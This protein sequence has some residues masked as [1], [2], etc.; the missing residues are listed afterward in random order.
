LTE[1]V[2]VTGSAY[3][4][5]RFRVEV[6][7]GPDVGLEFTSNSDE[8]TIGTEH[9]NDVALTDPTVSRHHCSLRVEP[10]GVMLRD[11]GSTNGTFVGGHRIES[12][13]LRSG[14]IIKVGESV[15]RFD[16]LAE[17]VREELSESESL[18]KLLGK[19]AAMR[20]VMAK[21]A[22]FA[23]STSTVLIEGETGCGKE[24]AAETIHRLSA[25]A[26][27]PFVVVDCGGLTASLIESELFGH[28]R[29]AFT[30]AEATR[31]GAVESAHGGTLFLDEIGE[32]PSE[33]QPKLLRVLER[34]TLVRVGSAHPIQVDIR[35]VAATNRDLQREVNAGTFRASLYHRLNV[36]RL[37]LP[38]LRER[39][40]DI[41]LLATAFYRRYIGDPA[42]VPPPELLDSVCRH[43]WPG[44]VREL[45]NAVERWVALGTAQISVAA[46]EREL[47]ID[48][49]DDDSIES[50]GDVYAEPFREVKDRV[51]AEWERSYLTR[52]V[53]RHGG[54]LSAAARAV[55]MDRNHLRVL[56]S[57]HRIT[58][59]GDG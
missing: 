45:R 42:A 57:R 22:C 36:L 33:L 6:V 20:R 2:L 30:G 47:S 15:L 26:R 25:R 51:V 14:S 17:H 56:L 37:R 5:Q 32:L 1:T 49:D 8:V 29:G 44:N 59:G 54:N 39:A 4:I 21:V 35:V 55:Q 40:E 24:L 58:R 10:R 38:P 48:D 11:L 16:P 18:G 19:S 27:G 43:S 50:T 9:G 7:G 34:Q 28:E 3:F 23:E 46:A 41:P 31:I 13:Q 52:L 12:A 53:R